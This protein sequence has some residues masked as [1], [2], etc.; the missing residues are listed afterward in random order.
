VYDQ[1]FRVNGP[2]F[3]AFCLAGGGEDPARVG[4]TTP[5][6]LGK[7][8]IRNR[9]RRR[10][11]EAFRKHLKELNPGWSIVVNPRKG[12]LAAGFPE[13]EAEVQKVIGRCNG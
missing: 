13:L 5:R 2:L 11:R 7:A 3:A 8:V 9:I 4:F 1:G 6:A 10:V 12:V